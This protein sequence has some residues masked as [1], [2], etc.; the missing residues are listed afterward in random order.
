M[1]DI[2]QSL[3]PNLPFPVVHVREKERS[4]K[5]QATHLSIEDLANWLANPEIKNN[6]I[7]IN[8]KVPKTDA[9][10]F[11]LI[12]RQAERKSSN[13]RRKKA[14]VFQLVEDSEA[15]PGPAT[16]AYRE[17]QRKKAPEIIDQKDGFEDDPKDL[18]KKVPWSVPFPDKECHQ[19]VWQKGIQTA[20]DMFKVD[21]AEYTFSTWFAGI[22]KKDFINILL[23]AK[24]E[25]EVA[26][27][28]KEVY[29]Q[30]GC[31]VGW[32]ISEKIESLIR[33]YKAE[34]KG[35]PEWIAFIEEH[36]ESAE[37]YEAGMTKEHAKKILDAIDDNRFLIRVKFVRDNSSYDGRHNYAFKIV[38]KYQPI[39]E[40]KKAG[41]KFIPGGPNVILTKKTKPGFWVGIDE[42]F[43]VKI[44]QGEKQSEYIELDANAVVYGLYRIREPDS[45]RLMLMKDG[46]L[47]CIALR[48]IE[49]FEK[50]K[51]GYGLT[52]TRKQKIGTW[53]KRMRQP[54]AQVEDVAELEKILKRPIKLLDI[55]HGTIFNSGKY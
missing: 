24:S 4:K 16:K 54:G 18:D 13:K 46:T 35:S 55:T 27:K 23:T 7:I 49:H 52:S 17:E 41:K 10:W 11:D 2:P 51:R 31:A 19:K 3:T 44:I 42:K 8:K 38:D 43:L 32:V 15:G 45:K 14:Q 25:K 22:L 47:N 34:D 29:L 36:F 33:E 26:K 20:K 53:E 28:A 39:R 48:V 40:S 30:R 1:Y 6:P 21:G 12:E 5:G 50:A 37:M 9:E